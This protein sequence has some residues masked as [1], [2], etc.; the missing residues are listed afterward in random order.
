MGLYEKS[1]VSIFFF[2]YT[3]MGRYFFLEQERTD[4]YVASGACRVSG[5]GIYPTGCCQRCLSRDRWWYLSHRRGSPEVF[6]VLAQH[7]FTCCT[8]V[9]PSLRSEFTMNHVS[10]IMS[11]ACQ[12]SVMNLNS[13]SWASLLLFSSLYTTMQSVVISGN[14]NQVRA[15]RTYVYR[16]QCSI[17]YLFFNT[18]LRL[19]SF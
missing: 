15:P 2:V 11:L 19:T 17:F 18:I 9:L 3:L 12:C 16:A 4:N 7:L 8:Y 13:R 10:W 1:G 14:G 5:G 6:R